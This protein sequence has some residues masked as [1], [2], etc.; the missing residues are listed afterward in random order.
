[1]SFETLPAGAAVPA[2]AA[3]VFDVN[4][5][6]FPAPYIYTL[7]RERNKAFHEVNFDWTFSINLPKDPSAQPYQLKMTSIPDQTINPGPDND[8]YGAMAESCFRDFGAHLKGAFG[9]SAKV[10]VV[11]PNQLIDPN[12]GGYP[13]IPPV[14][15]F[16][17][18]NFK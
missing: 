4:Y 18:N 3:V 14:P 10:N 13:A 11:D 9:F 17:P 15:S 8:Y 12:G 2:D 7:E 16:D 5:I 1:M 6:L